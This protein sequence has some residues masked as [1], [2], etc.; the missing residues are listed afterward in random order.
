[1]R[2]EHVGRLPEA[3]GVQ[4]SNTHSEFAMKPPK[5]VKVTVQISHP[6]P[7]EILRKYAST[8]PLRRP[9]PR[10]GQ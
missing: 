8:K 10:L 9:R 2:N 5:K 7:L 3:R 4:E 1:V 6:L